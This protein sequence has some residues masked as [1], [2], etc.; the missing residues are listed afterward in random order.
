MPG[1][2]RRRQSG[3]AIVLVAASAL[4]LSAILMLAL[5]GGLLFVDRRQIQSAA[6]AA[7]L[8]GGD[9]LWQAFPQTYTLSHQKAMT[10]LTANLPGTTM[11]S[12]FT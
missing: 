3:Q 1:R 9:Q 5:D 6:D 12:P 7:A 8:A 10:V 11:P 4:V 2:R